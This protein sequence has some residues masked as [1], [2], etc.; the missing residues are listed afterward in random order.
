MNGEISNGE[1]F[2]VMPRI[3]GQTR[4]FIDKIGYVDHSQHNGIRTNGNCLR[5]ETFQDTKPNKDLKI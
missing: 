3:P 1:E 4:K 2:Q 5:G